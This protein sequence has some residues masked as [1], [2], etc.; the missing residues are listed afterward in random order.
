[1]TDPMSASGPTVGLVIDCFNRSFSASEG[2]ILV[3]GADEPYYA[4]GSPNVI[5]FREDFVR[6]ALHEVAHWCVAGVARRTLPDYGYWYAPDGRNEAQQAAFFGVEVKPQAVEKM[7]C[8]AVGIPFEVSID[9]LSVSLSDSAIASFAG[10]VED[11]FE[12]MTIGGLSHRAEAFRRALSDFS[13][14]H[15]EPELSDSDHQS[16][17]ARVS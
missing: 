15:I 7:F 2:T 17:L 1:M 4:P 8:M 9:N 12:I 5:Y 3:G 6:S 13:R 16:Q 11:Q 14:R 10:A